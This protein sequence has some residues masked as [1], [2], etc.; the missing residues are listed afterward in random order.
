MNVCECMEVGPKK[1]PILYP[2]LKDLFGFCELDLWMARWFLLNAHNIFLLG[3]SIRG[4]DWT[5]VGV[6]VPAAS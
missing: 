3:R 2:R 6:E 1:R 5:G 4:V